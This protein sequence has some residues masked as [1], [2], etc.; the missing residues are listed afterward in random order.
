MI[1]SQIQKHFSESIQTK[2]VA[3]EA[4]PE[5]IEKAAKALAQS[6]I[7]GNKILVCGNGGAASLAQIFAS[8]LLNKYE[9]DRPSLP[10]IAITADSALVSAIASD[11]H[12]DEIYAKQISALSQTG[13][14][15]MVICHGGNSRNMIKA[16]ETALSKSIQIVAL[17]GVDGGELAGLLG[18]DDIEIRAPSDK[19]SRIEEIHLLVINCLS[20][21][22]DQQLFPTY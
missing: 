17:N 10:A 11:S 8:H 18:S 16:V 12:F 4:L 5:F 19:G 6:L 3:A 21:L 7:R 2:I 9:K 20:D 15:L 14:I 22:I 13:D 1:P